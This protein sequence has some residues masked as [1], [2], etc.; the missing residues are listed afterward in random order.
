[1]EL[2]ESPNP[3]GE[4][5]PDVI[6]MQVAHPNGKWLFLASA[7]NVMR[8]LNLEK[9]TLA[10][11]ERF[12][13]IQLN[14]R[15]VFSIDFR[16]D[17]EARMAMVALESEHDSS[18][19]EDDIMDIDEDMHNVLHV[20]NVTFDTETAAVKVEALM[21]RHLDM[22]VGY[23]DI[24]GDHIALIEDCDAELNQLHGAGSLHL[25]NWQ[26]NMFV[27]LPSVRNLTLHGY[28]PD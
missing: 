26:K 7:N 16:G 21:E 22:T 6:W 15:V 11:V 24:T 17:T 20:L 9:G 27:D 13:Q 1:M 5:P 19:D 28:I 3:L 23:L 12:G 8:I 25:F 14:N 4:E 18:E 10:W 2:E